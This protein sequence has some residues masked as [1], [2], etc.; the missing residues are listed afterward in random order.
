MRVLLRPALSL[1]A[2]ALGVLGYIIILVVL[3]RLSSLPGWYASLNTFNV[4]SQPVS[5]RPVPFIAHT[6]PGPFLLP[7]VPVQ[8]ATVKSESRQVSSQ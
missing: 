3:V 2:H 1:C 6:Q 4:L 5:G 7:I 8:P